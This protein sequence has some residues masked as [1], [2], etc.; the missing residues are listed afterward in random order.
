MN[1]THILHNMIV[2]L[3][4]SII[5]PVT[6]VQ[7]RTIDGVPP[8][9]ETN[10]EGLETRQ[11]GLC[12]AYCKGTDCN[13]VLHRTNNKA[14]MHILGQFE[15]ESGG[16][17]LICNACQ[18]RCEWAFR[19]A[20]DSNAKLLTLCLLDAPTPEQEQECREADDVRTTE[21]DITRNICLDR[22]QR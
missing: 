14:C 5:I 4:I 13:V 21:I 2:T 1:H 16:L 9:D 22:C 15:D 19:I 6:T 8:A 11:E 18:R 7:A 17:P 12:N 20:T 10:C 3:L